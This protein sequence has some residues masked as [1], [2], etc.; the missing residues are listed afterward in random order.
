MADPTSAVHKAVLAALQAACSCTIYDGVPQDAAYPYGVI[1]YSM[2]DNVDLLE[3]RI[4]DRSYFIKFYS[5]IAG[6]SQILGYFA[7]ADTLNRQ[8]LT[9]DTGAMVDLVVDSKRTFRDTD[10]L[11]FSGVVVLRIITTH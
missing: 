11:T 6:Q 8:T 4:D 1:E 5:R 9:L 3:T 7:E 10:N 2:A